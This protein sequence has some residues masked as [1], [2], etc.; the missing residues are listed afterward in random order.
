[1]ARTGPQRDFQGNRL[2]D[3]WPAEG[4][5]KLW[6]GNVGIGYSSF[7]VAKGR[8]YTMG[9]VQEKDY[10]YSLDAET[11][12]LRWRHE[13]P[14]ASRDDNGYHGTRCTPTVDEDRIY[15]LSRHGHF[16]CLD[17]ATGAVK[18]SKDFKK[19]FGGQAPK[20]GFP[21]RP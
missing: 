21:G 8:L 18:W 1:M 17:A 4:P 13:Y 20:W 3:Q 16:F 6:E 12:K 19:D 11:G 7:S 14:C 15:S 10:V 2:A 5:K 9:N